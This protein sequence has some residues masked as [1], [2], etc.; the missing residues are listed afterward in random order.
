[1][2][3]AWSIVALGDSVPSGFHCNCTPYPHLSAQGRSAT[4]GQV[5]AATN[6]AVA[7]YTTSNVLQQLNSDSTVIDQLRK[8]DAVEINVGANDVPYS[9]NSCGTS[10]DCYAPL[11]PP[12]QKNLASI[13]SRV[14]SL[15]SGRT[16]L[17]V[18][19]DYWS[20]WLGGTYARDKG[21]ALREPQDRW[22]TRPTSG[23]PVGAPLFLTLD[24]ANPPPTSRRPLAYVVSPLTPST[25]SDA[26]L[27]A[28]PPALSTI[29]RASWAACVACPLSSSAR[30]DAWAVARSAAAATLSP[31]LPA[32]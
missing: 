16:V 32:S 17:V 29:S 25:R 11:V 26:A 7:G 31:A 20:I 13:V 18:L 12:M 1:V 14:R 28:S 22:W 27:L 2:S 9:T 3:R 10:V 4:T 21:H 30:C 19:L 8:A 15:T 6:D 5:V 24:D 23:T